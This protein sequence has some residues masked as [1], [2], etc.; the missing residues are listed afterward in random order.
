MNVQFQSED[1]VTCIHIL[2]QRVGKHIPATQSQS[3]NKTSIFRQRRCKHASI[4][5]EDSV[6]RGVRP[7]AVQRGSHIARM[8]IGSSSTDGSRR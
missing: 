5:I 1:I 4:T 6:L 7:E 2:R 8:G 3:T